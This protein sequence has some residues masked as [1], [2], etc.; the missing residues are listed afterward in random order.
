MRAAIG[1]GS[2]PYV[3]GNLAV[4]LALVGD[5]MFSQRPSVEALLQST[6]PRYRVMIYNGALDIICGAPLTER[7]VAL[8]EWPGAAAL[9]ATPRAVWPDAELN[10]GTVAGFVRAA[11]SNGAGTL[12]QAVV[13]GGGHMVPFDQP[14]RSYDLITGFVN[15]RFG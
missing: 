4:E 6:S 10:D 15:G 14:A 13:R 12:V 3:D 1:V 7:Y 2:A 9:Y 8:L 11:A 5:V